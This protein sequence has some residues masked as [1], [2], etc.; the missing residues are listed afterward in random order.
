MHLIEA[1][2]YPKQY[3]FAVTNKG[4]GGLLRRWGEGA[5]MIRK[6]WNPRDKDASKSSTTGMP[7]E[8]MEEDDESDDE[9]EESDDEEVDDDDINEPVP[10]LSK[11]QPTKPRTTLDP[12]DALADE[13]SSLSL[14]PSSI[15]FGR[16]ARRGTFY[17]NESHTQS[18]RGRGNPAINKR[19]G[20][21]VPPATVSSPPRG[22]MAQAPLKR[23][24]PDRMAVDSA[25]SPP[26]TGNLGSGVGTM[27]RGR[28]RASVIPVP[29]SLGRGAG[30]G[31][32]R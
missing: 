30:L 9:D 17:S 27:G 29:A 4:V 2:S 32:A 7:T 28:G 13:M 20:S 24:E 6:E 15:R 1:H 12:A 19:D 21:A 10:V 25:T 31:Q 26:R 11:A 16:G 5:G 14:I 18:S 8:H 3:F 22:T 23:Q